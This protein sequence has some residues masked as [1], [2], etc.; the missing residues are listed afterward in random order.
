M[1][2]RVL[3]SVALTLTAVSPPLVFGADSVP[4]PH[5]LSVGL[6]FGLNYKANFSNSATTF[7]PVDPGPA[8][9]GA[10]HTYDDGFVRVD[11]SGNFG[12]L[13]SYWGYQNASQVVGTSMEFHALGVPEASSITDDPQLGLELIYQ[14][15]L[16]AAAGGSSPR[17]GVE[18]GLGYTKINLQGSGSG[19][20]PVITDTYPLGVVQPPLAGYQGT[21]TGPGALLGATPVRT[22]G[23]AAVDSYQKLSGRLIGLRLGPFAEW[24]LTSNLGLTASAGFTFAPTRLYYDFSETITLANGASYSSSGHGSKRK[25][26]YGP[27]ANLMLRFIRGDRWSAYVGAQVQSLTTLEQSVGT[28]T[29]RFDPRTTV[30]FSVGITRRF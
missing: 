28:R 12:G 16:G 25:N 8:T 6:R 21:S 2:Q 29:A 23:T 24:D 9:A 19:T 18:F 10:N 17:W 14:R 3:L 15:I 7:N 30:D 13:T 27:Y 20:A 1:K 26:L 22:L 4:N 5:R 11:A